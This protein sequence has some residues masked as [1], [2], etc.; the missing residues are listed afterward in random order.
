MVL[1]VRQHGVPGGRIDRGRGVVVE[2]YSVHFQT[3]VRSIYRL[4]LQHSLQGESGACCRFTVYCYPV[5]YLAGDDI[6]KGPEQV[7][8]LDPVHGGAEALEGGQ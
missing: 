4:D 8:G 6:V 3:P 7:A 5:G 2:I 1:Q